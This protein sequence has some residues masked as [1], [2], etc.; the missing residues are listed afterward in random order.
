MGTRYKLVPVGALLTLI[1]VAIIGIAPASAALNATEGVTPTT[2]RVGIPY[3]NVDAAPLRA[4]GVNLNFGNVPDAFNA[5]IDNINEHGGINGR[6]IVPY[7]V[8]V[9]PV[10][11]APAATTCTQLTE[12]DSVFVVIAPLE[13]TCYLEHNV[14]VVDSIYPSSKSPTTAQDFS[15]TPPAMALDP[16]ELRAFDKQGIFK[17]K[18]V[19][20]IGGSTEDESELAVVQSD[21]AKLHIPVVTTAVVTAPQGDEAAVNAQIGPI[22]QRFQTDGANEVVAV[23]TAATVW[24]AALSAIQSTYNPPWVATNETDLTGAVGSGD[25]QSYLSN[26]VTASP[27]GNPTALWNN[28]GMQRCVHIIKKTYPSDQIRTFNA[29]LPDSEATWTAVEEACPFMALFDD[30][31]TAA[32]KNLTVSTFVRAGYGLKGVVIPGSNASLSFGPN[33]PYALGPIYMVHYD[34]STKTVVY[35]DTPLTG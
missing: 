19:A 9:N 31:A 23:G 5:V 30:I 13:A 16:L 3:V 17:H 29:T 24:P 21:M 15:L 18:K 1:L 7:I 4:I 35:S 33:R 28:A 34:P 22:V 12:D 8:A 26:V 32:G 25:G 2:I 10:G 20:L 27:L 14:P 11:T 6:K